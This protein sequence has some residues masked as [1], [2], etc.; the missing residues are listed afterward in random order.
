MN[1]RAFRVQVTYWLRFLYRFVDFGVGDSGF[2][3]GGAAQETRLVVIV[4]GNNLQ[5]QCADF[6]TMAH[7]RKQ[8]SIGAVQL[9]PVELAVGQAGEFFYLRHMEIVAGNGIRYLT[10]GCLDAR[11]IESD[12][13][14]NFHDLK[15]PAIP[16]WRVRFAIPALRLMTHS[17]SLSRVKFSRWTPIVLK[18][19]GPFG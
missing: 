12:I 11:R 10:V 3:D 14:E 9:C 6:V 13:F 15:P 17:A 19:Q 2:V 4:I 7:K 18:K 1:G 16:N 8:Q 5:H